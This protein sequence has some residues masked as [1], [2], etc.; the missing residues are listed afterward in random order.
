VHRTVVLENEQI[1]FLF[2][3]K[4]EPAD[5]HVGLW[6]RHVVCGAHRARALVPDDDAVVDARSSDQAL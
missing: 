4:A 3:E 1:D 6:L 5:E 2:L